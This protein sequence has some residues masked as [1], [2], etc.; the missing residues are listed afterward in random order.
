MRFLIILLAVIALCETA[1][2]QTTLPSIEVWASTTDGASV[3]IPGGMV[4]GVFATSMRRSPLDSN[5][6]IALTKQQV[7]STLKAN[8]PPNC[9]ITTYPPAP[10]IPSASGAIF[11][12]NGC[13]S[14]IWSNV[15]ASIG[16]NVKY[17]G[18]YSGDLNAP[19]AGNK[20]IDF[21]SSCMK[22]DSCYSGS[23]PGKNGCDT[24]F[25]N[26]L[27]HGLC[28]GSTD[29]NSC[30][31]FAMDYVDAV[32]YHGDA[33]YAEDQENLRCAAWG[34]SMKQNQCK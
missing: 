31:D 6:T 12:G 32:T 1:R 29:K 22:H 33:A 13:G 3:M 11:S 4:V 19:V 14:G 26:N 30:Y 18:R 17:G 23:F 2:S 9:S 7:C 8:P 5:D 24:Q 20:S 28:D 34:Y 27:E 21:T 25:M 16:L 15:F 10:N